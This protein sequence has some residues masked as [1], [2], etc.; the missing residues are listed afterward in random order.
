MWKRVVV[1]M[2]AAVFLGAGAGL[3]EEQATDAPKSDAEPR[4]EREDRSR[5]RPGRPDD[6]PEVVVELGEFWLGVEC[7]PAPPPL[8]EQLGISDHGGLVVE[9]VVPE[10][11]AER[12][13]L[14]RNDVIVR[15]GEEP[16][17]RIPELVAAVNQAGEGELKLEVIRGGKRR[18]ITATPAP[19]PR[20]D[21]PGAFKEFPGD[22]DL[23]RL[24]QWFGRMGPGEEWRRPFRLHFFHP[25]AIL[26]PGAELHPPL[27]ENLSVTISKK[28]EEPTKI[29]V[30]RDDDVWEL[31]EQELE[32]LPD[33]VRPHVERMLGRFPLGAAGFRV[34]PR[35]SGQ[36]V[37]PE[38]RPGPPDTQDEPGPEADRMQQHM[39]RQ[40]DEMGQRLEEMRRSLDRWRGHRD[41]MPRKPE[42]LRLE[43]PARDK[44]SPD[45]I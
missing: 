20:M 27:P 39:E 5:A 16:V 40:L 32:D 38:P 41:S 42:R 18:E 13:G 34:L 11:P 7:Y 10:S 14:K 29:V 9:Q 26:P 23:D 2:L 44:P 1:V 22:E 37:Q 4:R 30:T 25:G 24:W 15:A 33:D 35:R 12:A 31:T 43:R 21:R 17:S 28:G 6:A 45:E 3:A 36:P 8:A 19:R